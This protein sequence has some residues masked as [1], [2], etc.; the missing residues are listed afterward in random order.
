ME[1]A[2]FIDVVLFD[3]V[4][5]ELIIITL[6]SAVD[7]ILDDCLGHARAVVAF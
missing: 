2:D 4:L 1:K 3:V 6:R 5:V 7:L